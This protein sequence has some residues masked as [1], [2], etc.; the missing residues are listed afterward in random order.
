M[1]KDH[2]FCNPEK[3]YKKNQ[4]IKFFINGEFYEHDEKLQKTLTNLNIRDP[5]HDKNLLIMSVTGSIN[6]NVFK[7][8]QRLLGNETFFPINNYL[9]NN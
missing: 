9:F 8:T 6:Q 4:K 3:L 1:S 5:S 2:P 7:L